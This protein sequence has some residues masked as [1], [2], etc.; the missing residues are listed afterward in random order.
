MN[1]KMNRSEVRGNMIRHLLLAAAVAATLAGCSSAQASPLLNGTPTSQG[2][3]ASKRAVA[4]KLAVDASGGSADGTPWEYD[5][6]NPDAQAFVQRVVTCL[7]RKGVQYAEVDAE[8]SGDRLTFSLGGPNNDR[9]SIT[10]GLDLI[11]QCEREVA[12]AQR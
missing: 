10:R 2:A 6:K 11:P 5:I 12:A 8:P 7:H 3:E 4:S 9:T 1:G